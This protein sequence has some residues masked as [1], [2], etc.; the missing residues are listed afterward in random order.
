MHDATN[1]LNEQ[2]KKKLWPPGG[3]NN[4]EILTILGDTKYYSVTLIM[5]IC[6]F[7]KY[8]GL[9]IK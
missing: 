4:L 8:T 3:I 5:L 1:D 2:T 9:L 6:T 7:C